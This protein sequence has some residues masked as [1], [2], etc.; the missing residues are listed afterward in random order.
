MARASRPW[1]EFGHFQ[2]QKS[3]VIRAVKCVCPLANI[4]TPT[5]YNSIAQGQRAKRVPP[6]VKAVRRTNPVRVVQQCE[7]HSP[8]S[9]SY[10][11]VRSRSVCPSRD[12]A[13]CFVEKMVQPHICAGDCAMP[14]PSCFVQP[15]SGLAIW[16]FVPRV[17]L[18]VLADPG[19]LSCTPL[20]YRIASCCGALALSVPLLSETPLRY[21]GTQAEH[22]FN[23]KDKTKTSKLQS[24][25]RRPCYF[26]CHLS[27]I[28]HHAPFSF[29][30]LGDALE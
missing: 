8:K 3:S 4:C 13:R 27:G 10:A 22:I 1:L 28:S 20:A 5:G 21:I 7:T 15:F 25:A 30:R 9:W 23:G 16:A 18:A 19:L 17:A 24:R 26:L 12:T 6:W 2:P 11:C 29:Y 14:S